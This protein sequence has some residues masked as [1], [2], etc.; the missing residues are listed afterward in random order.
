MSKRIVKTLEKTKLK[1]S[2][3]VVAVSA[4]PSEESPEKFSFQIEELI[5]VIFKSNRYCYN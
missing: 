4:N 3:S 5:Q 1:D 2:L